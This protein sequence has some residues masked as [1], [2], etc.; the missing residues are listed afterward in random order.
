MTY[1]TRW[2]V[3][4]LLA[5][6]VLMLGG[7]ISVPFNRQEPLRYVELAGSGQPVVYMLRIDGVISSDSSREGL[8][9]PVVAPST[10][11]RVR[12]ELERLETDHIRPAALLLRINSPGGTVT[13]S[14]II[15]HELSEYKRKTGVPVV[16][17]VLDMAASGGYYVAMA[18]DSIVAHPTGVVGSVGVIVPAVNIFQLLDKFGIKDTSVTSGPFKSLYT[19]TKPVQPEHQKVIQALV[20]DMYRQFVG[21]VAD[22]RKGRLKQPVEKLADGRVFSAREAL[23]LGLVDKVGYFED[24]LQEVRRLTGLSE[25][26]LVTLER[27]PREDDTSTR[28]MRRDGASPMAG[29][30]FSPASSMSPFYYLWWPN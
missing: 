11:E 20:D 24:G 5:G 15:Y 9:N 28:Y 22:G 13:A 10:V 7:C 14:D 8:V 23:R 27:K 1:F 29:L 30:L 12:M 4:L 6:A 21:V 25:F 17:L 3:G 19:P 16:A 18:S 2:A 26:R